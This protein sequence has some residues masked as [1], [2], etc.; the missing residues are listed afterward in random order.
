MRNGDAHIHARKLRPADEASLALASKGLFQIKAAQHRKSRH[1]NHTANYL[2]QIRRR[3]QCE[4]QM[5]CFFPSTLSRAHL[6]PPSI[7]FHRHLSTIVKGFTIRW[8]SMLPM[9]SALAVSFTE[10][11][12]RSDLNASAPYHSTSGNKNA[13][14][15]T[16]CST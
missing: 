1:T 10:S 5:G 8:C 13:C 4:T 3:T 7:A 14:C 12:D 11:V 2:R 6:K 16:L 15:I 9:A